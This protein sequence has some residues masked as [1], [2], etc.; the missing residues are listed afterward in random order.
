MHFKTRSIAIL[1]LSSSK[2]RSIE[3][4]AIGPL[5]LGHALAG[6]KRQTLHRLCTALKKTATNPS[7]Y[8]HPR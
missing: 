5:P 6:D 3:S 1:L 7:Q 8:I 2:N 4:L